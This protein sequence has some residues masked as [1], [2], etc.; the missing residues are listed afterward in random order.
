[1]KGCRIMCKWGQFTDINLARRLFTCLLDKSQ[2]YWFL[3][4]CKLIF[5]LST[6]YRMAA[7]RF[8]LKVNGAEMHVLHLGGYIKGNY[9]IYKYV[10]YAKLG[11]YITC[12][13]NERSRSI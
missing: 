7:P 5:S 8:S 11:A 10:M 6:F 3:I 2:Q 1:M 4:T 13:D 12:K 9:I